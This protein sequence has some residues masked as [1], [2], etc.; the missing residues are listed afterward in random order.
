MENKK[1]RLYSISFSPWSEKARWALDH[2]RISYEEVEHYPFAGELRLRILLRKPTGRVTVPILDDRGALLTDSFDI[3][4]HADAVGAGPKLF[5]AGREAEVEA[6]NRRS[7]TTLA[8][9]RA[10]MMLKFVDDPTFG[11][12]ALPRGTPEAIVPLLMPIGR[13]AM[14]LFVAKYRMRDGA[15]AHRAVAEEGLETLDKALAEGQKYLLGDTFSYADIAMALVLQVV[16][17]VDKRFMPTGP[18]GRAGWSNPDL[19]ERYA[20]LV[21]WRDELYENHRR[22]V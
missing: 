20:R 14:Q 5:P 16:S 12:A 2:H 22:W 9:L 1:T 8:A 11:R 15:E 19:A 7:E 13:G 6:W 4:R 17:P 18:G 10:M 21:K 3:A